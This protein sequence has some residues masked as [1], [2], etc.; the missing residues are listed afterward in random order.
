MTPIDALIL[1]REYKDMGHKSKAAQHVVDQAHAILVEEATRLMQ[2]ETGSL[3]VTCWGDGFHR[4]GNL[5]Q[6]PCEACG[7]SG[8]R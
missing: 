3:C 7:G 5:L 6:G 4:V 8:Q 2:K 1:L